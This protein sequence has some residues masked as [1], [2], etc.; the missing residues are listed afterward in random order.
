[1]KKDKRALYTG[2]TAFLLI[3]ASVLITLIVLSFAYS[4]LGGYNS[5]YPIVKQ[6]GPGELKNNYLYVYL[7]S[8]R[9][10]TIISISVNGYTSSISVPLSEGSQLVKIPLPKG[11]YY[12][13]GTYYS[14]N[15]GLSDGE[16]VV[17][18]ASCLSS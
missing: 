3:V 14:I 13:N 12:T 6:S 8:S 18:S 5:V 1:M 9:N 15:L 16:S 4:V 7:T 17:V 10:I 11:F 2:I